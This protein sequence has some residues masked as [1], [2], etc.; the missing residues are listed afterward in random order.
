MHAQKQVAQP[1][2][3]SASG[4]NKKIKSYPMDTMHAQKHVPQKVT[5]RSKK[6]YVALVC[7]ISMNLIC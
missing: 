2:L 7:Q 4:A 6:V 1:K 5:G 3:K